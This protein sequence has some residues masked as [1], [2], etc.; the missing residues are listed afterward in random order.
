MK[1][2]FAL[3]AFIF[4][5]IAV[6]GQSLS[7]YG[8]KNHD[9]F[10][11][12]LNCGKYEDNSIWNKFGDFG[13]RFNDK[14]IWNRHGDYGGKYSDFSPFNKHAVCPPVLIDNSGN[15]YGYFTADN[16]YDQRTDSKLALLVLDMW[17]NISEDV[18][19]YYEKLCRR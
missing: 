3:L 6:H 15:F 18:T 9:I 7:I 5:W 4:L 1:S 11:G 2:T 16:Y 17:E 13:C 14:C 10:L 8:G 12:C 19:G